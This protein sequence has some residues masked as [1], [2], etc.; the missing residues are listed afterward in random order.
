M[1]NDEILAA[2]AGSGAGVGLAGEQ[3]V[4]NRVKQPHR[5]PL[6]I[7]RIPFVKNLA[8]EVTP[9]FGGDCIGHKFAALI[10]F[11]AFDVLVEDDA[12]FVPQ[13]A[14]DRQ[15]LAYRRAVD[16]GEDIEFD[17]MTSQ[18][19]QAAQHCRMSAAAVGR[20]PIE[21]MPSLRAIDADPT[22]KRY[23]ARNSPQASSRSVPLVCKALAKLTP[24][25]PCFSM[26]P[27]ARRKKSM[28][29]SVGS[30]PCQ[31]RE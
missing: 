13:I 12:E 3:L 11:N 20:A 2:F 24:R 1:L 26:K 9:L 17:P 5:H 22:K 15:R 4:Q 29:A 6:L 25:L 30:P 14:V 23:S 16:Q 27:T 28:P 19:I 10:V 18:D 31:A 8:E 21:V 7:L